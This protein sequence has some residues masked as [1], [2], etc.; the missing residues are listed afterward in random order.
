[1][2]ILVYH[3]KYMHSSCFCLI[4]EFILDLPK[5]SLD[6]PFHI[7]VL[8]FISLILLFFHLKREVSNFI[9]DLVCLSLERLIQL[10]TSVFHLTQVFI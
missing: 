8:V 5:S 1:M 2:L 3:I 4:H 9:N 6:A 10:E 7:G